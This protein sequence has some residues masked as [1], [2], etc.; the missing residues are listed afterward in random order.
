MLVNGASGISSGYAT[1]IPPH[2]LRE[3]IKSNRLKKI[4]KPNISIDRL[5]QIVTGP[6][7]PTG[8]IVQGKHGIRQALETGSGKVI[9]R[10]KTSFETNG[11]RPN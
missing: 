4:D 2:N 5:L 8:G 6:D 10:S 1:K 11:Q 3:V 7:F 9:V